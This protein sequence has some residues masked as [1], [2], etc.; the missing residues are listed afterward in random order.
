MQIDHICAI[1]LF[2]LALS[3]QETIG[4]INRTVADSIGP[5]GRFPNAA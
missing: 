5:V 2:T 3:G 1:W 4:R